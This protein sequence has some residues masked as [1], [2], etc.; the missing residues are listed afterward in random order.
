MQPTL[1]GSWTDEMSWKTGKRMEREEIRR[2]GWEAN[3]D[4]R[5][6][7]QRGA[8]IVCETRQ[9][10]LTLIIW[11][12][13]CWY[14]CFNAKTNKHKS[15]CSV[16][17]L[18]A[19]LLWQYTVIEKLPKDEGWLW[20]FYE[21]INLQGKHPQKYLVSLMQ[22]RLATVFHSSLDKASPGDV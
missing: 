4:R 13:G 20:T 18:R 14:K 11:C 7:V 22:T 3:I 21:A 6:Q 15:D 12:R 5:E 8:K 1:L 10:L 19:N 2:Q 16:P 17:K 9:P